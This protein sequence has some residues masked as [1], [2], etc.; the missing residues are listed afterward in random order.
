MNNPYSKSQYGAVNGYGVT[1][2]RT[3]AP[4][5]VQQQH[6][7]PAAYV[8]DAAERLFDVQRVISAGG[9]LAGQISPES[10]PPFERLWRRLPE[11]GMFSTQLSPSKP[12]VFELGA[13]T[14]PARM[15]LLIFNMRP[16]VYRFSGVNS[17]DYAPIEARRFASIMGFELTIGQAHPGNIDFQINPVQI[18]NTSQQAFQS[19]NTNTPA[20]TTQLAIARASQNANTQGTSSMILPQRPERFG[21]PY[22]IPFTLY[23]TAGQTVQARCNIFRP[24]PLPI[25]FV[26]FDLT[27][28]LVPE[29]Y[30]KSMQIAGMIPQT[31]GSEVMR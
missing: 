25:A 9:D 15:T 31:K 7:S 28:L 26:E 11:E 14:V 20:D 22:P 24:I 6:S 8:P 27:G 5:P 16:D 13:F 23:V 10:L 3:Q 18:Q 2:P 30:A 12:F 1:V 19:N 17:G 4:I 21:A 29:N